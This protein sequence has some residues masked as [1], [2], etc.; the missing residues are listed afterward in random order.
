MVVRAGRVG[1]RRLG[2]WEFL[3]PTP[4]CVR[5]LSAQSSGCVG[6]L[7]LPSPAG[8]VCTRAEMLV[9]D[10]HA[11]GARRESSKPRARCSSSLAWKPREAV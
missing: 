6:A 9:L 5:L 2:T 8:L 11:Q 4:A 7:V 10:T 3:S 1:E